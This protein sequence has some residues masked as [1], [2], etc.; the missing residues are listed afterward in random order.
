MIV[1]CCVMA[2]SLWRLLYWLGWKYFTALVWVGG[3][4]RDG[5]VC[6]GCIL[7]LGRVRWLMFLFVF[8]FANCRHNIGIMLIIFAKLNH[9]KIFNSNL[10]LSQFTFFILSSLKNRC[11]KFVLFEEYVLSQNKL[12]NYFSYPSLSID[13]IGQMKSFY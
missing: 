2:L 1:K 13:L 12:K 4:G 9:L 3:V 5:R 11:P 7:M 8:D 10:F 6:M